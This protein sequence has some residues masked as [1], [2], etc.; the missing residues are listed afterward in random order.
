[1]A[2]VL[3]ETGE[4]VVVLNGRAEIGP[5]A[6]GGRSILAAPTDLAMKALLNKIKDREYYRPVAPICL[7]DQAPAIFDPGTPDPYMLFEHHVREEWVDR[8]PAVIHLDGTARLQTVDRAD[9]PF[10]EQVLREYY[11]ITGVPV[12]CN[13]SA[14]HHGRGFFPDVASAAEWGG[15]D[16]IWCAG[17]LHR[18]VRG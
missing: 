11:R 9:D 2:A 18:R 10:V 6:L 15:A 17:L 13:T 12:L 4:P 3:H 8:I 7:T 14:N 1:L 16:M 5:R